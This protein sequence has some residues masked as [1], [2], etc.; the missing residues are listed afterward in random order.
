MKKV[1]ERKIKAFYLFHCPS[2]VSTFGNMTKSCEEAGYN[3][4]YARCEHRGILEIDSLTDR[5]AGYWK[6]LEFLLPKIV[7]VLEKWFNTLTDDVEIKH[8]R[9][10]IKLLRLLAEIAGKFI[11]REEKITHNIDEKRAVVIYA[12]SEEHRKAIQEKI[13]V[14]SSQLEQIDVESK[15]SG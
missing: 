3:K 7:L 13:A 9:E 4:D 5:M 15:E 12:T 11:K 6:K 1:D 14:L 8:I 2:C 10:L